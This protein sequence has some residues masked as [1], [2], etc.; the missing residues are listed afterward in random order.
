MFVNH[1]NFYKLLP[2]PY[3]LPINVQFYIYKII[4]SLSAP[5]WSHRVNLSSER[6]FAKTY[7]TVDTQSPKSLHYSQEFSLPSFRFVQRVRCVERKG[8]D[9][10]RN[11][12]GVSPDPRGR[13]QVGPS[14]VWTPLSYLM[15]GLK[16][17]GWSVRDR[18]PYLFTFFFLHEAESTSVPPNTHLTSVPRI[19]FDGV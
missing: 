17:K 5:P 16:R 3:P 19:K 4:K 12:E 15:F 9:T 14:S 13:L 2:L 11:L 7:E 10:T 18:T 6:G 8:K 1:V